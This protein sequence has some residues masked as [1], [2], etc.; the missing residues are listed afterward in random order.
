MSFEIN[1]TPRAKNN[2]D[3]I[4]T[5]LSE[6]WSNS[7]SKSFE[8]KVK[9]FTEIIKEF[10]NLGSVEYNSKGIRGFQITKQIRIFYRI[11]GTRIIILALFDTRQ[12]PKKRP[13]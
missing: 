12:H 11:K 5:Y 1:W 13:R 9:D 3:S 6:E 2:L 7:T 4:K 10:P 8:S